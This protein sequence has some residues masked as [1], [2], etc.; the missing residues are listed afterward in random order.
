MIPNVT[1]NIILHGIIIGGITKRLIAM[2]STKYTCNEFRKYKIMIDN[3]DPKI[4]WVIP[5]RMN[6]NLI[7]KKEHT[8]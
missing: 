7:K 3:I 1:P 2:D 6:G 8:T 5:S 4:P